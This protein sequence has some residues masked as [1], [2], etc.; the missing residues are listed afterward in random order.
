MIPKPI[1]AALRGPHITH[2]PPRIVIT[3]DRNGDLPA[4]LVD[5]VDH[6]GRTVSGMWLIS[7]PR[8]IPGETYY[9]WVESRG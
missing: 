2:H 4:L 9:D 8:R 6:Q 7:D 5:P 1:V 3:P